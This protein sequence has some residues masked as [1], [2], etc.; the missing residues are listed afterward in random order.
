M[1]QQS[2][3]GKAII[4]CTAIEL[5]HSFGRRNYRLGG[6]RWVINKGGVHHSHFVPQDGFT[7]PLFLNKVLPTA[8]LAAFLL[9][10]F[11]TPEKHPFCE[12]IW[13]VLQT[14]WLRLILEAVSTVS[15]AP[16]LHFTKYHM[17]VWSFH[18]AVN[19]KAKPSHGQ[20]CHKCPLG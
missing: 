12:V 16:Q 20:H 15:L 18:Q 10:F 3:A 7:E 14:L 19:E 5:L 9:F 11:G 13:V 4:Y 1:C 2:G 6:A 8:L 17:V